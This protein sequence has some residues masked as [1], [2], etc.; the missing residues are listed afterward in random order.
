MHFGLRPSVGVAP[1]S[2]CA[3][4]HLSMTN[5]IISQEY[6]GTIDI[7]PIKDERIRLE[8]PREMTVGM[9]H[10]RH[11]LQGFVIKVWK[12]DEHGALQQSFLLAALANFAHL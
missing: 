6:S 10:C 7:D 1:E 8:R 9:R 2:I 3:R 5:L 12:C 11:I 4:W